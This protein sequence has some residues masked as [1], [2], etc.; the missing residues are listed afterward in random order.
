MHKIDRFKVFGGADR[1]IL[2]AWAPSSSLARTINGHLFMER[3]SATNHLVLA[4]FRDRPLA[5]QLTAFPGIPKLYGDILV[6]LERTLHGAVSLPLAQHW[7]EQLMAAVDDA[8]ASEEGSVA[9]RSSL[10]GGQQTLA[11]LV[12]DWQAFNA[13]QHPGRELFPGPSPLRYA[14]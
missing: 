3:S 12:A 10:I 1:G 6:Q 2:F 9:R 5:S 13:L 4:S 7:F 11:A 8:V 14:F